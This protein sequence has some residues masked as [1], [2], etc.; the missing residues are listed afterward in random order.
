MNVA[1]VSLVLVVK[2]HKAC[3]HMNVV[4]E[5]RQRFSCEVFTS[6]KLDAGDWVPTFVWLVSLSLEMVNLCYL[7]WQKSC[8]HNDILTAL[9]AVFLL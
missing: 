8:L 3:H 5:T 9:P 1:G 4:T 7:T 6:T 2:F